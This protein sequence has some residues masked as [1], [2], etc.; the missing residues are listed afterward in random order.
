MIILVYFHLIVWEKMT[1]W[2]LVILK[3]S[4][5]Y[6]IESLKTHLN[7]NN[8]KLFTLNKINRIEN[9][10]ATEIKEREAM[11]KNLNKFIASFDYIEM[12]L[13]AL[14]VISGYFLQALLIFL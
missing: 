9:Y 5:W 1:I 14:S 4:K 6:S 13:I 12:I 7:L 11:G 10:F 2:L 3:I 8:K